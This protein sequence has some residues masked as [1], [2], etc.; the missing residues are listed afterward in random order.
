MRREGRGAGS[1]PCGGRAEFGG[2][3]HG[4]HGGGRGGPQAGRGQA[5]AHRSQGAQRVTRRDAL[6]GGPHGR[7]E[8]VVRA[9]GHLVAARGRRA[10]LQVDDRRGR[11][12]RR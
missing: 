7:G 3:E 1:H 8:G 12:R 9:G 4:G 11:G 2:P 5:I 6:Q 10:Q